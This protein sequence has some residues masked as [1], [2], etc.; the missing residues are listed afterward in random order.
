MN[1]FYEE[2]GVLPN[3][4]QF[5]L[6]QRSFAEIVPN[7][8]LSNLNEYKLDSG[9]FIESGSLY[10]DTIQRALDCG[11]TTV[12]SIEIDEGL[13]NLV[14]GRFEEQIKNGTVKLF[15]GSTI[16]VLPNILKNIDKPVT[17]WLDAHLHNDDYGVVHNAPVV[18]ELS[19]ISEHHIK[20]HLVMVDDMRIIR[21]ANWGRGNMEQTVLDN[22][23][24][25]N[26]D[27]GITY[28]NGLNVNDVLI[29]KI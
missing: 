25:I 16:G 28:R 15:L 26:P 23:K 5:D 27:Y 20:N 2:H 22:I 3:K 21:S 7:H 19:I 17:F 14:K 9:I 24:T 13:Y 18:E 8:P 11:Y 29:A 1:N 12:Y 10:G 6:Y 4:E